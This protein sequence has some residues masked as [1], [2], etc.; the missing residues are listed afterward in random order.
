[1][2]RLVRSGSEPTPAPARSISRPR[3]GGQGVVETV[4]QV[5]DDRLVQVA[6][7]EVRLCPQ[8]LLADGQR[9]VQLVAPQ[10]QPPQIEQGSQVAR[11]DSEDL[12]VGG[13]RLVRTAEIVEHQTLVEVRVYV[14][15]SQ[16]KR[17]VE[18]G[19]RL[20]LAAGA[21]QSVAALDEV[22]LGRGGPILDLRLVGR[23]GERSE[24]PGAQRGAEQPRL[25]LHTLVAEAAFAVTADHVLA[26]ERAR[27]G[28][29]HRVAPG[30]RR[31]R[32]HPVA[33]VGGTVVDRHARLQWRART[34]HPMRMR[35]A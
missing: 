19:E 14:A 2:A 6:E 21:G 28:A 12:A 35:P 16:L 34:T 31:D 13:G 22:D 15:R 20:A 1:M 33:E 30:N 8:R 32:D 24:T 23:V 17:L 18:R 9:L 26:G 7:Y 10:V 4:H 5:Q 25:L 27:V 11:V 29:S 3:A